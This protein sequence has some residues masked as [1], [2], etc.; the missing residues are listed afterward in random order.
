MNN[1]DLRTL[2]E[3]VN[4]I[5]VAGSTDITAHVMESLSTGVIRLLDE[6]KRLSD[7]LADEILGA[8]SVPA[9]LR[10][11]APITPSDIPDGYQEV[12]LDEENER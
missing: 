3:R 11:E 7:M 8:P 5:I 6:N 1:T 2:A 9:E 10:Q 12:D 4:R